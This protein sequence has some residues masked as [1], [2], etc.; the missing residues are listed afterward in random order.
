MSLRVRIRVAMTCEVMDRTA[1][2]GQ[3]FGHQPIETNG[4]KYA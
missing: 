4:R 3:D 2:P 1:D